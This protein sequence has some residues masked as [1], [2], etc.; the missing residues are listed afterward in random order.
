MLT[1]THCH[2]D[3]PDYSGDLNEVLKRAKEA[4]VVFIV[5]VSSSLKAARDSLEIAKSHDFVYSSVGLHPHEAEN[6]S[7]EDISSI[8]SLA[9]NNKVVAIGECG[10]DYYRRHDTE[11]QKRLFNSHI[12]IALSLGLPLII[13]SRDSHQDMLAILKERFSSSKAK[14]VLHCF[15]GDETFLSG[16]LALGLCVSFTCN[17]TYKKADALREMV[18]KAPLEKILLETDAPFLS[19]NQFRGRRNEPAYV[20]YL[21]QAIAEIKGVSFVEVA[22]ETGKNARELFNIRAVT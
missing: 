16:C 5:N 15:S 4:G 14:G 3:F 19:P 12:D 9:V 18:K 11:K 1:D 7:P 6:Y 21:A 13:H 17:I 2:L 10:L 22:E 20:R 8:K